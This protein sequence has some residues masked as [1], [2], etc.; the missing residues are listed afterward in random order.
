MSRHSLAV[1]AMGQVTGTVPSATS[2]PFTFIVT[3]SGPRGIGDQDGSSRSR[4]APCRS[5][6]CSCAADLRPL[7]LEE[8]VLVTEDAV[9]DE[10]GDAAGEP[11]Q[12]VEHAIGVGGDLGVDGDDVGSGAQGRGG[13][14]RHAD[15]VA[16]EGPFR[17]GR[18][19]RSSGWNRGIQS[20]PPIGSASFFAASMRKSSFKCSSFSGISAARS[21]AWLQSS[22]RLYSSQVSLS[23]VH[24]KMPGGNP[25]TQG[26]RGP[27]A[28]AIQPWW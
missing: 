28:E 25:R 4:S 12:L 2:S 1:K 15:G 14:L 22:S 13:E 21:L 23:G 18:C 17:V 6:A 16:E 9:L 10:A 19:G 11:A 7:D 8:V 5:A 26:T 20:P 3:F 27:N 24:S